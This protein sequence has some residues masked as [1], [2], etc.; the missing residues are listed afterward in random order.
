MAEAFI[1][2]ELGE[3]AAKAGR[4][5]TTLS[6]AARGAAT[7]SAS[8]LG[9]TVQKLRNVV[10][11]AAVQTT[12]FSTRVPV[13][14]ESY[15]KP[16]G[17]PDTFKSSGV[18]PKAP[19]PP[20]PAPPPPGPLAPSASTSSL[21]SSSSLRSKPPLPD[22]S[23]PPPSTLESGLNSA[24]EVFFN[25]PT[26]DPVT[27]A[28]LDTV[29]P[30]ANVLPTFAYDEYL[31]PQ[32]VS[33]DE[34]PEPQKRSIRS[35]VRA[36][37][38]STVGEFSDTF[39][40]MFNREPSV[41]EINQF[42][43]EVNGKVKKGGKKGGPASESIELRPQAST[44]S[45][46][47]SFASNSIEDNVE[48]SQT[49]GDNPPWK[50]ASNK[51]KKTTST[52]KRIKKAS[53]KALDRVLNAK[54]PGLPRLPKK[55]RL[56]GKRAAAA[57]AKTEPAG[58]ELRDGR[59]ASSKTPSARGSGG[60]APRP[61]EVET[62]FSLPP[63]I[64]PDSTALYNP[65]FVGGGST[66]ASSRGTGTTVGERV[67]SKRANIVSRIRSGG[68]RLADRTRNALADVRVPDSVKNLSRRIRSSVRRG[69]G[70]VET[71]PKTIETSGGRGGG[72]GGGTASRTT[73]ST[74]PAAAR[75]V[76]SA[77]TRSTRRPASRNGNRRLL[78]ITRGGK[79]VLRT[80]TPYYGIGVVTGKRN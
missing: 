57:A 36:G 28:Y 77:T 13:P 3:L 80:L 79:K 44:S 17:L 22:F 58:V 52:V 38:R 63:A 76:D 32:A 56:R 6:A 35:A 54:I 8:S 19:A 26:F 78:E 43:K 74:R 47:T 48:P 10:K 49:Y 11:P 40:R 64:T 51:A 41:K 31:E 4:A 59:A 62:S 70:G 20:P 5:R 12:S 14:L 37:L 33:V 50:E 29:D 60:A 30:T 23:R 46:P 72:G 21:S 69:G 75:S 73:G 45:A 39:Y 15:A 68:S 61:I 16:K 27:P 53:S 2:R 67:N 1:L 9:S 25:T 65:N 7:R 34:L 55:I 71:I 24:R 18:K 66:T 42:S